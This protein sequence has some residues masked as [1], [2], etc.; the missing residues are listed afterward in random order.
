VWSCH[1]QPGSGR[2]T[3]P[4]A[5]V[6][7]GWFFVIL[8]CSKGF[9]ILPVILKVRHLYLWLWLLHFPLGI[10]QNMLLIW[11]IYDTV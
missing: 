11:C 5:G 10:A 2:P 6:Q 7:E 3:L 8:L 4:S 9:P 1:I